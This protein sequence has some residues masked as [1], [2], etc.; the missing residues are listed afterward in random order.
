MTAGTAAAFAA[1]RLGAGLLDTLTGCTSPDALPTPAVVAAS[2]PSGA[3]AIDCA[4]QIG[5]APPPAD[6]AV[7]L[8]AATFPT[9]VLEP[10]GLPEGRYWAKTGLAVKTGVAVD[11][12]VAPEAAGHAFI[13]WGSPGTAAAHQW[14]PACA[15]TGWYAY[16]GGSRRRRARARA[17]DRARRGSRGAYGCRGRQA[18]LTGPGHRAPGPAVLCGRYAVRG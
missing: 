6:F 5:N 9:E 12:I 10:L 7:V 11:V 18:V 4:Y 8:A 1:G 13:E 3:V 14:V 15:G 2:P 17:A 16:A